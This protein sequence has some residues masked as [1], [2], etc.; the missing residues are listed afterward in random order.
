MEYQSV[1]NIDKQVHDNFVK[2]SPLCNLLQSS[3][4]GKIKDNWQNFLFSVTSGGEVVASS[5][6]LVKTIKMG[7]KVFYIPRGPIMDYTNQELVKFY[8]DELKKYAKDRKC[9]FIK[10]DPAVIYQ[11]YQIGDVPQADPQAQQIINTLTNLGINHHGFSM[12]I[13]DTFQPRIVMGIYQDQDYQN[14]L[15]RRTL[16]SMRSATKKGV[17]VN[18][19]GIEYLDEFSRLMELTEQR[20]G[21]SLRNKDYFLKLLTTYPDTGYLYLAKVDINKRIEHLEEE[22]EQLLIQYN[23]QDITNK[24]KKKLD[25]QITLVDEEL[26]QLRELASKYPEEEFISGGIMVGFGDQMELLYAGMNDDFKHFYPQ[27]LTYTKQFDDSFNLGYSFCSMGGV[28]GSLDDGLSMYKKAYNPYVIE[29]IGEFDL[30]LNQ[31]L[32]MAYKA[33]MKLR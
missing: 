22:L 32:Y 20:K 27:Y 24:A 33:L 10:F 12:K 31:P 28:E 3:D 26:D 8:F 29:Y 9:V 17:E 30:V 4:W 5:L 13:K 7:Y 2:Q 11:Q 1:I 25:P 23:D 21:V 14:N 19:Y 18:R 16:K 15:P 6:V